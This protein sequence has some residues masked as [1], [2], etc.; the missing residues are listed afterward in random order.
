[1]KVAILYEFSGVVRDAFTNEGHN[2]ISCDIL[3]TA[4]DGKHHIGDAIKFC[5][6]TGPFNLVISFPPCTDLAVS[7][8]KY[9]RKKRL[10]GTQYNSINLFFETWKISNCVENPVGILNDSE[11]LKKWFPLLYLE[12]LTAGFPFSPTQIIQPW[13]FGHAESK[14]TCLWLRDLPILK[15]TKFAIPSRYRCSICGKIY[16]DSALNRL[17]CGKKTLPLWDNQTKTGQNKLGP[18]KN[19]ALIRSITYPGIAQ[20]MAK[21]WGGFT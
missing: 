4:S 16:F 8:A 21:Q 2:A 15:P 6:E 7:G 1:M 3:P 12:M 18:S 13:Q 17:C 5:K 11:Y 19:R 10:D 14:K 9:F 20:A